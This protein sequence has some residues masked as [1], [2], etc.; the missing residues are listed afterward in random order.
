MTAGAKP[1]LRSSF[2]IS[3]KAAFVLRRR[4]MRMSR[5]S[6]SL[7][8]ARQPEP[9]APD[10]DHHLVEVPGRARPRSPAPQLAGEERPELEHPA[11]DRLIGHVQPAL[12]QEDFDVAEAERKP[13]IEPDRVPDDLGRETMTMERRAAQHPTSLPRQLHVTTPPKVVINF[14][15]SLANYQSVNYPEKEAFRKALQNGG[16]Y[17]EW[18]KRYGDVAWSILERYSG[19]FG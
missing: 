2:L 11:P 16:F 7:S 14:N 5:T 19:P 4:C 13:E 6:P 3:R 15:G 1:C 12:G 10:P 9:F 17:A 18:K 8:T